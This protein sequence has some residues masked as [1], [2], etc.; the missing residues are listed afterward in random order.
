MLG[1]DDQ[2]V[3]EHAR[4]LGGVRLGSGRGR[5]RFSLGRVERALICPE[6]C[7][8]ELRHSSLDEQEKV[9]IDL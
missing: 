9:V 7:R 3:L 2:W 5:L 8:G 6:R 4:R 1:V